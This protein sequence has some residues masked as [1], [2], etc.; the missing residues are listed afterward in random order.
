[1]YRI[2]F[3]RVTAKIARRQGIID[4]ILT[5]YYEIK[6]TLI[7]PL[8][9]R[10]W[11]AYNEDVIIDRLLNKKDKGFYIDVG[12]YDSWV[13]SN[14]RR[15]YGRGWRGLNIEPEKERCEKIS[16]DRKY[17]INVHMGAG[18]REGELTFFVMSP[19]QLSTFSEKVAKSRILGG[20]KLT[21]KEKVSVDT[22]SNIYLKFAIG[23]EVDFMSIDTEGY[24]Y[25]VLRGIDW[26]VLKPKVLCVERNE[27]EVRAKIDDFLIGI[28]YDKVAETV[29]N[30]IFSLL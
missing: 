29:S 4:F 21:K 28:G 8:I 5:V 6:M 13:G 20:F 18:D 11:S 9:M 7:N 14:T 15:F 12:A 22:V 26:A 23:K 17:D 24:E 19:K 30:D 2:D 16:S 1:M 25:N 3:K 27:E 10:S